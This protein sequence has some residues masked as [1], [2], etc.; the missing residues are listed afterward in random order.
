[1]GMEGEDEEGDDN[2]EEDT[3]IY[4]TIQGIQVSCTP[5]PH[6]YL[7]AY[8]TGI[9]HNDPAPSPLP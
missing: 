5:H 7:H 9:V 4:D 3:D 8:I 1:M 2:G 6:N